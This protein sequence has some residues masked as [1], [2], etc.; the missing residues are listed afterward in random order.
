MWSI[1]ILVLVVVWPSEQSTSRDDDPSSPCYGQPNGRFVNNPASCRAF[2]SCQDGTATAINCP[3]GYNFNEATQL[4]ALEQD[5]PCIS[6]TIPPITDTPTTTEATTTEPTTP[7]PSDREV[8]RGRPDGYFINNPSSCDAYWTCYNQQAYESFCPN[9]MNFNEPMQVC[10]NPGNY[11]CLDGDI[12]SSPLPEDTTPEI[13]TP[14]ATTP[15][16]TTPEIP[17]T[18]PTDTTEQ[19]Q[20]TTTLVPPFRCPP[21]GIAAFPVP[22]TCTTYRFCFAGVLS[23][24]SCAEGMHFDENM[25]RCDLADRLNCVRGLCPK[26]N[27]PDNIVTHPSK[28]SCGA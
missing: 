27:D 19:E 3:V 6:T 10:D 1:A 9:G 8:C 28:N 4:C 17:S 20:E 12:S 24:R 7:I 16:P 21:K 11:P 25:S 2:W 18:I 5:F 15:E 13:T 22:D 26:E 14:E 23:I